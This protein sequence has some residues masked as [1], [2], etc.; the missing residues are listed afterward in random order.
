[1]K[2]KST[3]TGT[4]LEDV[5]KKAGVSVPT[6]SRVLSNSSYPVSQELRTKIL[7]AAKE[8]NYIPNLLG[9]MLK[10]NSTPAIG[11]IVPTLQNP[12]FN[13]VILGIESATR[14]TDYELTIFSSHRSVEQERKNIFTCLQNRVMALIVIS[15]DNNPDTL[16]H[17]IEYGGKVALLEADFKLE[18]AIVAE[19]E[20]L[21]AGQIA[22]KHLAECGH[23]NI[24]FLTAPLTKS[25]RQQILNGVKMIFAQKNIPFSDEDVLAAK[26]EQEAD[27]GQY[28]FQLGKNLVQDFLKL[29]KKYSA[30]IAINDIT[31]FGIIQ[32]LTQNGISVPEQVSVISFD[33][34]SYSEMISPPLT[35][36]ELPSS[37]MGFTACQMLLSAV[38]STLE[39]SA[40]ARF[41]FPCHLKQR[42]SVK[43]M[44]ENTHC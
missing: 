39:F 2:K 27:N 6:A 19:T 18:H 22:A 33:N 37:S 3:S 13:Q 21:V 17:Y 44:I 35:T 43:N 8:L 42:M 4:T 31:A 5:A 30:I 25:Y 32:A 41:R 10:M 15:I 23:K 28:E 9:K 40:E 38:S 1:M 29:P 24:V 12:F 16:N 7:R 11:V 26:T 34:I 20:Y 14:T 36:V